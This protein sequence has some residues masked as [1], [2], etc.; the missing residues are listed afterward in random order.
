M[1]VLRGDGVLLIGGWRK[2]GTRLVSIIPSGGTLIEN[3]A[4]TN[5]PTAVVSVTTNKVET[6]DAC[7]R[8][9]KVLEGSSGLSREYIESLSFTF[10]IEVKYENGKVSKERLH[11]KKPTSKDENGN[12]LKREERLYIIPD[13]KKAIRKAFSLCQKDDIVLLLG[14]AHENSII[15]K[16]YV[17]P[18]DE[19]SEAE[20]ALSEMGY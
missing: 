14:K 18:Y 10:E 17:M 19:I 6:E 8:I 9:I 2:E 7:I 16:D 13:R 1:P 15:Y 5:N 20:N 3:E 11:L 12:F 4:G